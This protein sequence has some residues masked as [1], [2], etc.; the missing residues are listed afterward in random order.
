[1]SKVPVL[2]DFDGTLVDTEPAIHESF[3]EVFRLHG[4][5][6]DFDDRKKI[7]VLGPPLDVMMLKYF[8]HLDPEVLKAEYREYQNAHL[9]ELIK[10]MEYMRELLTELKNKGYRIAVVSTRRTDSIE[11]IMNTAGMPG[12]FDVVIGHETVTR[13]K[14]DPEGI[15]MAKELLGYAAD[16]PCIYIGDSPM[17]I[18]CG[19]NA[20]AYT[21]AMISHP[22]KEEDVLAQKP[23]AV[24]YHLKD[25][26]NIIENY[27]GNEV[28]E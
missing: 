18:Q 12:V 19:K 11:R 3:R 28:Q 22:G 24:V 21:I 4:N 26:M 27:Q 23:D 25:L 13:Q 14:P 1:M 2:F 8:P 10:P 15:Y 17:D 6:E 5:V 7:E 20:H 9:P 16:T